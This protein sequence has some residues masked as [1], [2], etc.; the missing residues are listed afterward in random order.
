MRNKCL[1]SEIPSLWYFCYTAAQQTKTAG[2][3][4]RREKIAAFSCSGWVLNNP[5]ERSTG[6]DCHE[7][8]PG[9]VNSSNPVILWL[10]CCFKSLINIDTNFIVIRKVGGGEGGAEKAQ[11]NRNN[12]YDFMSINKE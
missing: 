2:S 12:A 3:I 10:E 11:E 7:S 1:L 9:A 5:S 8:L 4:Y 6:K